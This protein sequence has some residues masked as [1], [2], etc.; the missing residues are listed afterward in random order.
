MSELEML[1]VGKKKFDLFLNGN[2]YIHC[3]NQHEKEFLL[4]MIERAGI[5]WANGAKASDKRGMNRNNFIIHHRRLYHSSANVN[6][7]DRKVYYFKDVF[8]GNKFL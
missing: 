5:I 6:S 4:R 7:L 1:I 8:S 2:V 3:E